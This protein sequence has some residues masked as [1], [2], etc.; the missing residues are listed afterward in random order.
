MRMARES[1]PMDISQYD[2][3]EFSVCFMSAQECR[4]PRRALELR[5]AG[6][7]PCEKMP[8]FVSACN[9]AL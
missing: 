9:V 4:T 1:E 7:V 8:W 6:G 5:A 3:E 2:I